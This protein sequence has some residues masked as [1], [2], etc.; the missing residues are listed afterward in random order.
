MDKAEG[1]KRRGGAHIFTTIDGLSK[2]FIDLSI[3]EVGKEGYSGASLKQVYWKRI[4]E[5][6]NTEFKGTLPYDLDQKA[7]KNHW[8]SYKDGYQCLCALV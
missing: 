6:L 8:D 4:I 1:S 2:R 3:E 5:A 7:L